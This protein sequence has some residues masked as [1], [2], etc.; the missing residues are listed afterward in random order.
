MRLYFLLAGAVACSSPGVPP[1]VEGPTA[2]AHYFAGVGAPTPQRVHAAA[3]NTAPFSIVL[4]PDTQSYARNRRAHFLDQTTWIVEHRTTHNI[5]FVSHVGDVVQDGDDEAEW[6]HAEH[7]LAVL[8]DAV[9]WGVVAGNHDYNRFNGCGGPADRYLAFVGPQRFARHDWFG[10]AS[11]NG[12]NTYQIVDAGWRKLLFLHLEIDPPDEAIAWAQAVVDTHV[13]LPTV[14]TT[15]M[16]FASH[17]NRRAA[18]SHCNDAGNSAAMLW[19]RFIRKNSQVFLVL[20]GHWSAEAHLRSKNETGGDVAQ[21]M[22]NY[23]S[24][25]NGGNGFLQLVTIDPIGSHVTVR[26]LSPTLH[27][28]EIDENSRFSLPVDLSRFGAK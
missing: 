8:D 24:R 25:R 14:V 20:S 28:D 22:A 10:G 13:G 19:R 6:Q 21:L 9:P 17:G 27:L 11:E 26:T 12:M 23:Q 7:A 18:K 1:L 5:V 4:L 16:Y 2:P 3:A 15:H